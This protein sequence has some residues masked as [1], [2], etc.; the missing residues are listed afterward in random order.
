MTM[1]FKFPTWREAA[2]DLHQQWQ[3]K[4]EAGVRAA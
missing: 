4:L 1:S 2:S 3:L